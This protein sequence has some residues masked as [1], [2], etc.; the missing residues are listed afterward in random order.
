MVQ[1]GNS[2][3]CSALTPLSVTSP[4]SHKWIVPFQ[5]LIQ[6]GECVHFR[7]LWASPRD[8]PVRL[9]VSPIT[10]TP[11][12]F[13]SQ[14]FCIFSFLCWNPV[15]CGLS[16]SPVVPPGLSAHEHGTTWF[17]SCRLAWVVHHI[18]PHPLHWLPPSA[19]LTSLDECFFK[20]LVVGLPLSPPGITV[21]RLLVF[22][23]TTYLE[24]GQRN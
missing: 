17:V 16:C 6:M 24:K 22:K 2:A 13:S 8:S 18:A 11:T 9:G 4:A 23:A 10:T 12:D 21:V 14:R 3:T 15:F 19:P 20:S 1:R 5:V 7:T